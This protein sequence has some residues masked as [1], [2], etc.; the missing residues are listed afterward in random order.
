MCDFFGRN[1]MVV[2][3]GSPSPGLGM[4][5][6]SST[7]SWQVLQSWECI[8]TLQLPR[9]KSCMHGQKKGELHLSHLS[10]LDPSQGPQLAVLASRVSACRTKVQNH[11]SVVLMQNR[12]NSDSNCRRTEGNSWFYCKLQRMIIQ[13]EKI[14]QRHQ[15]LLPATNVRAISGWWKSCVLVQIDGAAF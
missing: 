12:S 13:F 5:T 7:P 2:W 1:T 6:M 11:D 4:E 15:N 9:Y 8:S 14:L 3:T 10:Q